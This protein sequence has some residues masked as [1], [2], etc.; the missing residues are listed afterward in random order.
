MIWHD[1]RD[2][3]DPRLQELALKYNLHPLHLEDVR[4]RNQSAKVEPLNGYLFVV[5]K[6][7]EM[8][9]ECTLNIADLDF[10]IGPDWLITIQEERCAAV[11]SALDKVEGV[12]GTLRADEIFYR[13]MDSIVDSYHPI[14]DHVS[15]QIDQLED[16]ALENPDPD[17]LGAIFDLK[18][19]LMQLRRILANTRDVAGQMLRNDTGLIKSD[20]MPFLRDIYDHLM[21]N[22]DL[23]EI[24]RDLLNGATELYLSSVANR[25]NQVMKGMTILGTIATPALV[26]TGL[27]GMNLKSLPFAD[28]QHSWGIVIGIIALVS[29]MMLVILRRLKML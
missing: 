21:R 12:S 7:V 20:L 29:A 8:V 15:D 2:P 6:P 16:K 27:Y 23:V 25:T 4:N 24:N 19:V 26:I 17:V 18:R 9:D 5:L 13:V 14:I 3:N 11:T 22:L 28:A 1:L 10:F